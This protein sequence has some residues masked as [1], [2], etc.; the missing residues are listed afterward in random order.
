[1]AASALEFLDT[2]VIC[3]CAK[4]IVLGK[5]GLCSRCFPLLCDLCS[6][7]MCEAERVNVNNGMLICSSI[8]VLISRK[9]W[10]GVWRMMTFQDKLACAP[11]SVPDLATPLLGNNK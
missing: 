11:A 3:R 8:C 6:R 7:Q 4:P 9:T 5:S 1:M 2:V 10:A